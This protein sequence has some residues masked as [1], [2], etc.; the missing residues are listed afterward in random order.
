MSSREH[1]HPGNICAAPP[2]AP[3]GR[4]RLPGAVGA[5]PYAGRVIDLHTHSTASD[6]TLAPEDVVRAATA[7]GVGTLALTDHDTTAGWDRAAGAARAGGIVLVPGIEITCEFEDYSVH[8]LGY[9]VDP[10]DPQLTAVLTAARDSRVE[11]MD[12]IVAKMA[13]DGIPIDIEE[14]RA[15]A[16]PGATLGRPHLADALVAKGLQPDRDAVFTHW[17]R[18]DGPYYI[19]HY[20]PTPVVA[21]RLIRDAGGV[22]V[23]AHPFTVSRGRTLPVAVIKEMAAAGLAGLE[24]D[25]REHDKAARAAGR[26]LADRL[27]L[28]VTG[29]SDFHGDGKPNVLAENLTSPAVLETILATGTGTEVIR[30]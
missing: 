1:P 25:H 8:V 26:D 19:G 21:V 18:N 24:V 9:L 28:F 5:R 14:V 16:R 17:L 3:L 12:R 6:G 29:G 10:D 2:V 27:G 15:Q 30:P 7:A 13:A 23:H 20:A 22:A 11:R 4:A